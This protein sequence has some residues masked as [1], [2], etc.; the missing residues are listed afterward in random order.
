MNNMKEAVKVKDLLVD[1]YTIPNIPIKNLANA[2]D[3][4]I[5]QFKNSLKVGCISPIQTIK[6]Y[7]DYFNDIKKCFVQCVLNKEKSKSNIFVVQYKGYSIATA[8]KDKYG[9]HVSKRNRWM[10]YSL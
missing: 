8:M 7:K 10:R 9:F 2:V 1:Y 5:G 3:R 6:Y 4:V